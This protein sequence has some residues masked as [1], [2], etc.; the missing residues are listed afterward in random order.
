MV[1]DSDSRTVVVVTDEIWPQTAKEQDLNWMYMGSLFIDER[2]LDDVCNAFLNARYDCDDWTTAQSTT[3]WETVDPAATDQHPVAFHRCA[4][5]A[6][7]TIAERWLTL[8]RQRFDITEQCKMK[9]TGV[10]LDDIDGDDRSTVYDAVL[11]DH[12]IDARSHFFGNDIHVDYGPLY[13]TAT[14]Q[15]HQDAFTQQLSRVQDPLTSFGDVRFHAANHATYTWGTPAWKIAHLLQLT[16][17]VLGAA[18]NLFTDQH[19]VYKKAELAWM[20]RDL[21]QDSMAYEEPTV[22]RCTLAFFPKDASQKRDDFYYWRDIQRQ[23]PHKESL[24]RFL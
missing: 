14:D 10:D 16:N 12:L 22:D 18:A 6:V 23:D 19:L 3:A 4:D 5:T 1:A 11:R 17:V 20:L 9:F 15:D 13:H 2:F 21:V 24:D 8:I 7:H